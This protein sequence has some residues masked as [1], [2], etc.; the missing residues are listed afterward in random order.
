MASLEQLLSDLTSGDDARAEAAVP[1]LTIHGGPAIHSLRQL[2]DAPLED[3][4]WWACRALAALPHEAAGAGLVQALAN[5][6]LAVRQ[7]AA[8]GLRQ[9]P[10][11]TAINPLL[12]SLQN[13]DTLL[14][15]LAGDALAAAGRQAIPGLVQ[16]VEQGP[17]AVRIEVVRALAKMQHPDAIGPLFRSI[18][19]P[20]SLVQHWAEE[21]L[22]RLGIGMAFFQP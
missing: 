16:A 18:D 20:S 15:R 4:R 6:S 13:E 8:L 10:D 5:P 3:H 2:L 12:D 22:D 11:P 19:D 1:A 21:G 14:R 17:A 7:C 9:R